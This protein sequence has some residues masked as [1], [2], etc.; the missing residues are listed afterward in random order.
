[1]WWWTL[2]CMSKTF[3]VK[4]HVLE[5]LLIAQ[6]TA[7]Q[8]KE[9]FQLLPI[10]Y[11]WKCLLYLQRYEL[12]QTQ[13]RKK[14]LALLPASSRAIK[15][16][17]CLPYI[18]VLLSNNWTCISANTFHYKPPKSLHFSRAASSDA[19]KCGKT[20]S[21]AKHTWWLE[22]KVKSTH[23]VINWKKDYCSFR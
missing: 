4:Y 10:H 12:N 17:N 14:F 7:R 15:A 16:R 5:V 23:S 9:S 3:L 13:P 2:H 8:K 20:V 1:M 18:N 22:I 21:K 19:C 11:C 6:I